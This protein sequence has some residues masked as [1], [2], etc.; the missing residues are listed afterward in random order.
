MKIA[1]VSDRVYPF[2]KGGAE[3]RYWDIAKYLTKKGNE[4][5]F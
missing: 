2:F 3:K 5:C 1:I 4:V